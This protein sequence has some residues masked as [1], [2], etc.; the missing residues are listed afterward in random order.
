MRS[1]SA[2]PRHSFEASGAQRHAQRRGDHGLHRQA[3]RR[4]QKPIASMK[5]L[6]RHCWRKI[7]RLSVHL[8]QCARY[9]K[10]P[11]SDPSKRGRSNHLLVAF[12]AVL[13]FDCG[14]GSTVS[15]CSRHAAESAEDVLVDSFARSTGPWVASEA[16]P[17]PAQQTCT[18]HPLRK[19]KRTLLKMTT[20]ARQHVDTKRSRRRHASWKRM[21]YGGSVRMAGEPCVPG[22]ASSFTPDRDVSCGQ[23]TEFEIFPRDL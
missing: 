23:C 4:S 14:A 3:Q 10:L 18:S 13:K 12:T 21:A 9:E 17:G 19:W 8:Q 11:S 20:R 6:Q 7:G 22:F 5:K 2:V 1:A 16:G 15:C